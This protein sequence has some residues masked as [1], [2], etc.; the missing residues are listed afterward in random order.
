MSKD[1]DDLER[2]VT[3]T[4]D[5]KKGSTNDE[6]REDCEHREI[7]KVACVNKA[8][9]PCPHGSAPDGL[10]KARTRPDI[11]SNLAE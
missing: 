1:V 8:V 2:A 5:L 9:L 4:Y 6:E 11:M 10:K 7:G 3:A